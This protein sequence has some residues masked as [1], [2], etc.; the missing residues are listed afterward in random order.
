MPRL[1][2]S[3]RDK[4][5][6]RVSS[7]AL[8]RDGKLLFGHRIDSNK[9]CL[10]GGHLNPDETPLKGAIRELLEE[11]GLHPKPDTVEFLG[12]AEIPGK[13]VVVYSFRA[14]CDDDSE[15]SGAD[16]PD[17]EYDEFKWVNKEDTLPELHN[18]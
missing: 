18:K 15:P 13:G 6:T 7:I 14:E 3:Q 12:S 5:L 4:D 16:D 8:F 10:P 17:G 1:G 2:K 9:H 11:T